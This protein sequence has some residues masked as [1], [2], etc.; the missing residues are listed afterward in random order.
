MRLS[1]VSFGSAFR[2]IP[3]H[4]RPVRASNFS[5]LLTALEL[6][7]REA[8]HLTIVAGEDQLVPDGDERVVATCCARRMSRFFRVATSERARRLAAR[9]TFDLG[10]AADTDSD[11][12]AADDSDDE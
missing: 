9:V 6:L 4:G 11:T 5:E 10:D 12:D 8:G 3:E 7:A 1:I 2:V